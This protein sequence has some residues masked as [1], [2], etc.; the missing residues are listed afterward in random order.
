M[1]FHCLSNAFSHAF[2]AVLALTDSQTRSSG[3]CSQRSLRF[4]RYRNVF[5][6]DFSLNLLQFSSTLF[7]FSSD[8][9][10]KF[11]V[12]CFY[13]P[14]FILNIIRPKIRLKF[15]WFERIVWSLTHIC[16]RKA[17]TESCI[18]QLS[19]M[20]D[21][22]QNFIHYFESL[23]TTIAFIAKAFNRFLLQYLIQLKLFSY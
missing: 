20:C 5:L 2:A 9:L 13:S 22:I 4:I 21:T 14:L 7:L 15:V 17:F 1:L 18:N 23:F 16:F 10:I 12:L 6:I 11:S 3:Q 8:V 19:S